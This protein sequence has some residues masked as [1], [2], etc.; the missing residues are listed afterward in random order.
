MIDIE[1]RLNDLLY[2]IGVFDDIENEEQLQDIL[3]E[4]HVAL[5]RI[6]CDFANDN[7]MEYFPYV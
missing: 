5:D 4:C 3:Y 1:M 2:D 6:A 7:D